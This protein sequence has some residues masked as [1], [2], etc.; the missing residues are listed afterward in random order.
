MLL[1]MT[2]E[3]ED[4]VCISNSRECEEVSLSQ[5]GDAA[6]AGV[7]NARVANARLEISAPCCR[8]DISFLKCGATVHNN[9]NHKI[10]NQRSYTVKCVKK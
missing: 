7:A 2:M 8:L 5:R 3:M 10:A 9:Q 4:C 1:L 6:L